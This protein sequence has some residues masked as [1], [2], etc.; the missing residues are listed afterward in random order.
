M[1]GGAD[2][3]RLVGSADQ[4]VLWGAGESD[5]DGNDVLQGR[6][7]EYRGEDGN[8]TIMLA[9]AGQ[10]GAGLVV[11]GGAGTDAVLHHALRG[12]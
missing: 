2:N 6:A 11:D 10:P 4:D 3:D 8:D 9:V 7:K 12:R 5:A 1:E